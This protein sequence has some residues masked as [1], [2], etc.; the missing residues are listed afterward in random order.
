MKPK[1]RLGR[2]DIFTGNQ[3]VSKPASKPA[4]QQT[5]KEQ[6][7]TVSYYVTK[8]MKWKIKALAAQKEKEISELVREIF[9]EYFSK[10]N[11]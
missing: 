2:K 1:S 6:Y 8:Q 4:S 9:S 5:S 11:F 3:V 10:H 7:Q